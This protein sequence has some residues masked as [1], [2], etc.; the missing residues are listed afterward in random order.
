[1]D[2][3]GDFENFGSDEVTARALGV[4]MSMPVFQQWQKLSLPE[5]T[6]RWVNEA[7]AQQLMS[8]VATALPR[9]MEMD[10]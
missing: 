6:E 8:L 5:S 7:D 9:L 1:M 10:S 2:P 4:L 3:L